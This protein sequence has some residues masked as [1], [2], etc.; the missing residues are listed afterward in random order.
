MFISS[1]YFINQTSTSPLYWRWIRWSRGLWS[2]RAWG[3]CNA[4]FNRPSVFRIL[5]FWN[6]E[7]AGTGLPIGIS[8]LL[9][10]NIDWTSYQHL[11]AAVCAW[12]VADHRDG[13]EELR[14]SF[15]WLCPSGGLRTRAT[16][17]QRFKKTARARKIAR[18]FTL[19]LLQ[20][21]C[22]A[23]R[24]QKKWR[25][26]C[27]WTVE[28]YRYPQSIRP[29]WTYYTRTDEA[30]SSSASRLNQ[31]LDF[32]VLNECRPATSSADQPKLLAMK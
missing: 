28:G 9:L 23:D 30:T 31:K 29:V 13:S 4:H 21:I 6:G 18:N 20:G 5:T 12:T 10:A 26:T 7:E 32:S 15:S 16:N 17:S 27:T 24:H 3:S 1:Y 11:P 14:G 25:K 8:I 22:H 2:H 19:F